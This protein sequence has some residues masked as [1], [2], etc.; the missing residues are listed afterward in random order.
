MENEQKVVVVVSPYSTGVCFAK[1]ITHHGYKVICLWNSGLAENM[2]S[3]VPMSAADIRYLAEVDEQ[4]T[5][6]ET[7][8][9]LEEAT[10]GRPIVA[11]VCGGEAGVD[12][13]DALSEH[14]GLLTNGT[15]VLNRRDK[16]VQQEIIKT[17][18]LRS[19]RQAGGSNWSD[20]EE[21]LH[22][23]RYPVIV[24][25]VDSAGSDGVKL[26]H[27]FEEAREHFFYLRNEHAKVNGGECIDVLC[28]EFLKGRE[29]VVDH[30]SLNG[31]HKTMMVWLYDKRAANGGSF[32]YFG[33]HPV[34]ANSSEAQL[35]I[36]Y[37]RQVLD[38]LGV[39]NGPSHGE[40]ILTEDGPCLV[41]MNCRINGGDGSWQPLARA[42]TGGY[43]QVSAATAA[44]L[45]PEK[46]LE[47]NDVPPSPFF[48]SGQIVDLVSFAEGVVVDTPGFRRIQRLS[49]FISL[50]TGIRNGSKVSKT[51]DLITDVGQVVLINA[52]SQ[53]L[54]NDVDTIRNL[55]RANALFEFELCTPSTLL[56]RKFSVPKDGKPIVFGDAMPPSMYLE[57]KM[58]LQ[59]EPADMYMEI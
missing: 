24:K 44:Y 39:K 43:D 42:L 41:E 3:H 45:E 2:K 9:V 7:V 8:K 22:K 49:S 58:S 40:F 32:V 12:L 54:Q 19:T 5:L 6:D 1:E 33:E 26:C 21:F 35:L 59:K 57:R 46:F 4:A 53:V 30:V 37:A 48:A 23:E 38:A 31:E 56:E 18:G 51:V 13:S 55:E 17:K 11:V 16:K 25:P 36:P 14:M 29:Y 15:Y 27:T 20:V 34:P 47:L 52:D 50:E 10:E 28:Q